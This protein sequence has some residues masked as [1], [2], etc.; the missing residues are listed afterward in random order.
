MYPNRPRGNW[1]PYWEQEMECPKC[2]K[3]M[4]VKGCTEYDSQWGG[5]CE[6]SF[7]EFGEKDCDCE[8]TAEEEKQ[9]IMEA[10]E[11]AIDY[12]NDSY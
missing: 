1:S 6:P 4:T 7:E 5:W 8:F 12:M 9:L 10:Q 3:E 11:H 2:G